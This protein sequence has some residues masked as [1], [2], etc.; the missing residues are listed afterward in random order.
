[1]RSW[2]N[3]KGP[4][5]RGPAQRRRNETALVLSGELTDAHV[6]A[7]F[8]H[9]A[10]S[11]PGPVIVCSPGGST[12]IYEIFFDLVRGTDILVPTL[13]AGQAIS[14]GAVLVAAGRPR[15]SLSHTIYGLHEPAV[16]EMPEDPGAQQAEQYGLELAKKN[17]YSILQEVTGRRAGWWR[18]RLSGRSMLYFTAK[19]AKRFGLIDEIL[20]QGAAADVVGQSLEIQAPMPANEELG[21]AHGDGSAGHVEDGK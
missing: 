5:Q 10:Q 9:L 20:H 13:G 21:K 2:K 19:E 18:R 12:F 3:K 16:Y 8:R 1:M 7:L 15:L 4:G 17:F 11:A 14:A 6:P